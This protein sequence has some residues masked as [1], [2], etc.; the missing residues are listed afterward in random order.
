MTGKSS[1]SHPIRV[2]RSAAAARSTGSAPRYPSSTGL[3]R[4]PLIISSASVTVTGA[5][6][7]DRSASRPVNVPPIPTITSGPN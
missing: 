6:R 5:N 3:I 2:T 7:N 4:N 1:T